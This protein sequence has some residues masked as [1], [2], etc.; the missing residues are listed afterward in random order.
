MI[1]HATPHPAHFLPVQRRQVDTVE[2]YL[3]A[4]RL[5]QAQDQPSGSGL[6]ATALTNQAKHLAA[7]NAE[8]DAVDG[9]NELLLLG[10]DGL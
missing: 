6:T 4:R 3:P 7:A 2:R 1:C 10:R 5:Q 8:I 9:P